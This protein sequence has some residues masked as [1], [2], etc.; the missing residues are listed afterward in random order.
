MRWVKGL[1]AAPGF[2]LWFFLAVCRSTGQVLLDVL[3]P[4]QRATPRVV[5]LPLV[6]DHD[7]DATV[8]GILITLT[9][10]T[11]TLGLVDP[12]PGQQPNPGDDPHPARRALIVH[13][14]YDAD[15]D[16]A[17]TSLREMES[18]MLRVLRPGGGGER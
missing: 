12:R 18:R 8:L 4:G 5:Q 17:V 14:M 9:P 3:T 10:G 11:L 13:A 16:A 1:L 2:G 6:S 15:E 7:I